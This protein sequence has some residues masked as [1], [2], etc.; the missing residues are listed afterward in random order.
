MPSGIYKRLSLKDRILNKVK[1]T[2]SCWIWMGG[3]DSAGYGRTYIGGKAEGKSIY[4]IA[5]R[6]I[7]ELFR[8]TDISGLE[9][10]H[11]CRNKICVNPDHLDPVT[12]LENVRRGISGQYLRKRTHCPSGHEYSTSNTSFYKNMRSCKTCKRIKRRN[13]R[14]KIARHGQAPD[15]TENQNNPIS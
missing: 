5:H 3:K 6:I 15:L 1:K 4:R 13:R 2:P 11:I 10:D 9:L 7:Y 14:Q 12:H 8:G